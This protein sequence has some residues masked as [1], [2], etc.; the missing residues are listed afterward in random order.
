V[1]EFLGSIEQIPLADCPI[2]YRR[3]RI[4]HAIETGH[5]AVSFGRDP[6]TKPPVADVFLLAGN[7]T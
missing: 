5:G 7:I 6:R 3:R 2:I 1:V 4:A